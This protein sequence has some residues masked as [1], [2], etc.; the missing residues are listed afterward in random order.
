MSNDDFL[1]GTGTSLKFEKVGDSHSGKLVQIVSRIDK[2][3]N[4]KTKTW[5]DGE[6]K[7]VYIWELEQ[8]DGSMGAMWVRGNL[9]T[10]L[11]EAC[12]KAGAKS[13]A[14]LIGATIQVKHHDLGEAKKGQQPAKLFQAKVTLAP[15]SAADDKEYDPFE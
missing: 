10:V 12:K 11:R 3:M 13:S 1:G 4:G 2:D 7:K 15:K 8:E 14:D 9:V 5:D 6:P